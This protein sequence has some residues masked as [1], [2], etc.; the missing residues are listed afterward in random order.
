MKRSGELR[1]VAQK[2]AELALVYVGG[3]P[4]LNVAQSL[5]GAFEPTRLQLGAAEEAQVGVVPVA[6]DP[7]EIP[8]L[9]QVGYVPPFGGLDGIGHV[10]LHQ[11]S[12]SVDEALLSGVQPFQDVFNSL[13]LWSSAHA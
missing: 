1:G 4:D 8:S 11:A 10:L 6:D 7:G 3:R 13:A 12:E 5:P 2:A 9:Q